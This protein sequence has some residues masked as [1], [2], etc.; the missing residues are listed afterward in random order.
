MKIELNKGYVE[1]RETLAEDEIERDFNI[2]ENIARFEKDKSE[3]IEGRYSKVQQAS[4]IANLRDK[5]RKNHVDYQI[6][7]VVKHI[8]SFNID[9]VEDRNGLSDFVRKLP[10]NDW[11]KLQ[12]AIL[13]GGEYT[14]DDKKN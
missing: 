11:K 4:Q 2:S 10:R 7:Y 8:E 3:V 13:N 14:E 9:G 1:L 12:S 5:M 6:E